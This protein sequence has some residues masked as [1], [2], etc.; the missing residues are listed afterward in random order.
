M[1]ES[2][3]FLFYRQHS[4]WETNLAQDTESTLP[5]HKLQHRTATR[6]SLNRSRYDARLSRHIHALG[7]GRVRR[8]PGHRALLFAVLERP[9]GL[10]GPIDG[11]AGERVAFQVGLDGVGEGQPV[12][13][14]DIGAGHNGVAA[15]LV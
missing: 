4:H 13:A 15:E 12:N 11:V 6:S 8:P 5:V 14:V 10:A 9:V 2:T 3:V 7:V 1:R